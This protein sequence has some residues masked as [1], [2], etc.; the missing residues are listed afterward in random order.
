MNPNP[1]NKPPIM[2]KAMPFHAK[3]PKYTK[4]IKPRTEMDKFQLLES[5]KVDN[6]TNTIEYLLVHHIFHT[7]ITH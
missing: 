2:H 1:P 3:K 5:M 4:P 7:F 6:V